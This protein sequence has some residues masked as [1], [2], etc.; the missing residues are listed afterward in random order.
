MNSDDV[1]RPVTQ[2]G[3]SDRDIAAA[4]V[5]DVMCLHQHQSAR[6]LVVWSKWR[7]LATE[8]AV[9]WRPLRVCSLC[10]ATTGESL[11]R[12]GV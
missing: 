7:T 10:G 12:F 6:P 4:G 2:D 5:T 1:N 11:P 9:Y 8:F 3:V